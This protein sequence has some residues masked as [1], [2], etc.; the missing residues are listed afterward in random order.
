MNPITQAEAV[1]IA[2]EIRKTAA[3]LRRTITVACPPFVY[4]TRI[5]SKSSTAL[6][7]GAQNM[8]VKE[9]G[10]FTGEVS[11]L[12]LRDLGAEYV[13]IG[14]SE[15]R[16][17]LGETNDMVAMK[18]L[19]SFDAGIT[20]VVCVGEKERDAQ[21]SYLEILKDQITAS[22]N[23]VTQKNFQKLIIAYEPI[24]AIGAKEPMTNDLMHETVIFI[25]KILADMYGQS[26]AMSIPILYGGSVN[27]RN[28]ADIVREGAVDGLLVG[29]ESVNILGFKELLKAVDGIK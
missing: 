15:R 25:R 22:L 19:L 1:H 16:E 6:R 20:P 17:H 24:W 29:R 10:S 3:T 14:H 13:I 7:L 12:M 9:Q 28:A 8:Y 5:A 2:R 23:G 21:G 26:E 4:I 27:A 11:A 18:T